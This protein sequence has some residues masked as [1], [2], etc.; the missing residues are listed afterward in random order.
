M[1]STQAQRSS[2]NLW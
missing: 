2:S 1:K